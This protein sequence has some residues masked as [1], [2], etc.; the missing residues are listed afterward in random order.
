MAVFVR[1]YLGEQPPRPLHRR[2]FPDSLLLHTMRAVFT[3]WAGSNVS[4]QLISQLVGWLAGSCRLTS[5][6]IREKAS[7]RFSV[8]TTQD[9]TP[10]KPHRDSIHQPIVQHP[11]LHRRPVVF[12]TFK[13]GGWETATCSWIK[14]L[15]PGSVLGLPITEQY[16]MQQMFVCTWLQM[17]LYTLTACICKHSKTIQRIC[18][19]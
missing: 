14:L 12:K 18:T 6:W 5:R 4:F 8:S 1:Y 9:M 15:G 7:S 3:F 16:I 19:Y 13:T 11:L 17:D 2:W 10:P